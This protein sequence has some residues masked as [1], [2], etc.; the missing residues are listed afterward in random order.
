MLHDV[1]GIDSIHHFKTV[2]ER[3]A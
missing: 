1:F 3:T 2:I